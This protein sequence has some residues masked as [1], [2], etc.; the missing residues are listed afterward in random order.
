MKNFKQFANEHAWRDCGQ[1]YYDDCSDEEKHD[2]R[3]EYQDYARQCYFQ[4]RQEEEESFE[5]YCEYYKEE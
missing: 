5:R 2:I 3:N 4:E 1:P